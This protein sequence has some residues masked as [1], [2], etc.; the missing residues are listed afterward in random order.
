MPSVLTGQEK[1]SVQDSLRKSAANIFID[2]SRCDM[3]YI[4]AEIPY[5]NY[6]R[7]V[8]EADVYILET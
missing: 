5:V 3:N 6:V 4:R 1:V 7:D 2:C 8:R